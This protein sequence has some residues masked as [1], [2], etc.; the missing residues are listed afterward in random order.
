MRQLIE[1]VITTQV[2]KTNKNMHS[3]LS[4]IECN[5]GAVW[6]KIV[7]L[8]NPQNWSYL[9]SVKRVSGQHDT[10]S[11]TSSSNDVFAT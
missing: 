3:K 8:K 6:E 5:M 9:D 10:D 11:A 7:G 1:A 2:G 4:A